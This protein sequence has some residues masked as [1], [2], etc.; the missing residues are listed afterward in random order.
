MTLNVF[1][2]YAK[3]NQT[4]AENY[5][6]WLEKEGFSPWLDIKKLGIRNR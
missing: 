2:S 5:Y 4:I 1:I 3:E 6:T